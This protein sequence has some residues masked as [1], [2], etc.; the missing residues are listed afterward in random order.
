MDYK[1]LL[2]EAIKHGEILAFLRGEKQYRIETSQYMPGVEPTDAG[3]VLSKAIYKSYK[4]SPEIKE[5]FEDALI[6]MLNGD[7]MDIY[8]VVLYV[9]S[10]LFK[11]MNDIA[12]FKINKN[13]IIAKLQN[14]IAENKKLLSEDIKL[15]DGFIKKGVWNNIERFDSVCNM[16]YGFRLIV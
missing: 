16:E 11:E 13:F 14:K 15:S 5:I 3:K 10:Q 9:T 7:A 1:I 8:L 6:N 4:E 12:P 2:D